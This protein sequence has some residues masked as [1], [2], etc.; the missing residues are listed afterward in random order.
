ME[1]AGAGEHGR[2]FIVV[3]Q[4]SGSYQRKR[5]LRLRK[6]RTNLSNPQE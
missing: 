1:A 5:G 3:A 4:R 2:G 6:L